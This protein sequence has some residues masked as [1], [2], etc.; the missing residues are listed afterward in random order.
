MSHR[1]KSSR[2]PY[3]SRRN[4]SP[5]ANAHARQNPTASFASR[6]VN[7]AASVASWRVNADPPSKNRV[8]D[9]FGETQSRTSVSWS[10]VVEPHRE[11][12]PEVTTTAQDAEYTAL[13]YYGYRY[14]SPELG[15]WP[16][17]DPIGEHGGINVFSFV[18]N[19]AVELVDTL[20]K[21]PTAP[22]AGKAFNIC[23]CLWGAFTIHYEF[24]W[25]P[26]YDSFSEKIFSPNSKPFKNGC[27]H[28]RYVKVEVTPKGGFSEI[29][30][31]KKGNSCA[32][33]T[34]SLLPRVPSKYYVERKWRYHPMVFF[35]DG[36]GGNLA[37][38]K[39]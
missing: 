6:R 10:Q 5:K 36:E 20:G 37:S 27:Y 16:S 19:A 39:L 2:K 32:A 8:W 11:I 30:D 23:D 3:T 18:H 38:V 21:K 22:K 9:F 7:P 35:D 14:Y 26:F 12:D 4:F 28:A 13:Y 17:R 1:G 24:R 33:W 15:R 29:Y 25:G 34:G 31:P